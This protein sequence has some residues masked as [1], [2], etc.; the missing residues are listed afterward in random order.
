M[1]KFFSLAAVL[2]LLP[3]A[4]T[5][6]A[7]AQT[8]VCT[9]MGNQL[10]SGQPFLLG[11]CLR[12]N[13]GRYA[14]EMQTNGDLALYDL[15][16]STLVWDTGTTGS[17]VTFAL[18]DGQG[19]LDLFGSK[20]IYSN[21]GGQGLGSYYLTLQ[22]DGNLVTYKQTWSTNTSETLN[23]QPLAP[24]CTLVGS[25][26]MGQPLN[27]GSCLLAVNTLFEVAMQANGQLVLYD[28]VNN[29]ALWSTPTEGLN[30]SYAMVESDGEL[31]LFDA[32]HNVLWTDGAVG[33]QGTY[34][35]NLLNNGDAGT[36][37]AVWTTNTG[38]TTP[39]LLMGGNLDQVTGWRY[40]VTGGC[41]PHAPTTY[42]LTQNNL[43][44]S[45]DGSDL[46]TYQATNT[47][48][49]WGILYYLTDHLTSTQQ[50][51]TNYTAE[52]S[53]Q[54]DNI[55]SVQALE[56]DF[57]VVLNNLKFYFGTQ[58][59]PNGYWQYWNP[60]TSHWNNTTLHCTQVTAGW[61]TLRWLG[62]RTDTE[63]TYSK[64]EIDGALYDVSITLP[65][66]TRHSGDPSN[67]TLTVQFQPDGRPNSGFHEY[68]DKVNAWAW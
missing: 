44:P 28:L 48:N 32:N 16:S 42:Q 68:V 65:A 34:T 10:N 21:H 29:R 33:S 35:L 59:V 11:S 63:Y 57:P 31:A 55:S 67:G 6:P 66:S 1:K 24:A 12:S 51:A 41:A 19:N 58:C 46:A 30:V 23:S 5:L 52:W 37:S 2:A 9:V 40:C 36:Y 61:H 54:V 45:L 17:P 49:Y 39:S 18:L 60:N 20:M 26:V 64:L 15:G 56:F 38:T 53:Y 4:F 25:L 8:R 50:Q 22:D 14:L 27:T 7:A 43:A 62:T 47:N 3:I 13:N